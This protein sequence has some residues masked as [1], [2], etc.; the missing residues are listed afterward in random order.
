[1]FNL[2]TLTALIESRG[3]ARALYLFPTKALAQD[4]CRALRTLARG[5]DMLAF[6]RVATFDGDTPAEDRERL[7]AETHVFLTNPDMVHRTILAQHARWGAVLRE[8]RYVL[9][10]EVHVY[11]GLFGS[12][13]AL[14]VRRLRRLCAHY[15]NPNVQFICC[16]ATIGAPTLTPATLARRRGLC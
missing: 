6:L 1:M 11:S 2:P 14:V 7:R 9:L 5:S 3:R 12:H 10:D 8:L 13:V 16:S 4:Q 15:G